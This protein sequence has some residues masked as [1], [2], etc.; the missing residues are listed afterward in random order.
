M[1]KSLYEQF[2][3]W[4]KRL[5]KPTRQQSGDILIREPFNK[6]FEAAD[7][8]DIEKGRRLVDPPLWVTIS[9]LLDER[10][11]DINNKGRL[12]DFLYTTIYSYKTS[13]PSQREAQPD[14][15]F[16]QGAKVGQEDKILFGH[17]FKRSFPK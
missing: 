17:H 10:L 12:N 4:R 14:L 15:W 8:N 5:R 11:Q 9:H 7:R 13:Q 1:Q 2:E 3:Q 16:C 6:Q